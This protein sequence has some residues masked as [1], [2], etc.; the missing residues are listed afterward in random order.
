[1]SFN[2]VDLVKDQIGGSLMGQMG[3]MLGDESSLAA[4]AVDNAVPAL[5]EGLR[6][7]TS[8]SQG[9]DALF[10]AVQ[11]QDDGLLDNLG[12]MLGGGQGTQLIENGTSMLG[13][14][15]G[16]GGLGSLGGVLSAVSG[17]S[18][19]GSGS[20]LGMLAP[21]V[22]GVLKRKVMGNGLNAG[23]LASMLMGQK[24]NISRSMPVGLT[25]QLS[26]TGFLGSISG[27]LGG[28]GGAATGAVAGAGA[29]A[30]GAAAAA[31]GSVGD[32]A[33]GAMGAVG[34]AAGGVR[35]A[36]GNAVSG[37]TG[38]VGDVAGGARDA[39]GGVAGSVTDAAG[40]AVSGV[41]D[42]AGNLAS[43][44]RDAVGGVA[45]SVGDAAG[46]VRDAAGNAV[47]GVTD[48]AGNVAG[49]ARDAVGSVA[50][51]VGDAAG[52]VR[53][54]AGNAV[55]GM[56]DAAGNV[57]DGARDAVGDAAGG[58]R[59]A[60]GNAVGGVTDA[61]GNVVDGARDAVGSVA[62]S[63]G[64]AAG[65]VRDAAGNAV[66]GASGAVGDAASSTANAAA[67]T[68][69]DAQSSGGGW[70]KKLIPLVGLLLLGW[71]G[72]KFFGG[73]AEET[74]TDAA[75][76]TETAATAVAGDIDVGAVGGEVTGFFDSA[77]E[78]FSGI[79]DEASATSS[80]GKLEELSGSL[81]GL[82][83]KFSQIPE[84]ARGPVSDIVNTG[85]ENLTPII[86][87]VQGI[88]GVGGV[89]G[90]V[91]EPMLEMLKGMG[92]Q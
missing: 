69:R 13:S 49:G 92:G 38:A 53:D 47:S 25:D 91:V 66:S 31:A 5:L 48:A 56:T 60:A 37:V 27:G 20:L 70:L 32:V 3:S 83:D 4:G 84:A 58:V 12:G 23:G 8:N 50:G 34:D 2:I 72:L 36:A 86:E 80:I 62:G 22:V 75:S 55:G 79:T 11:D 26:S 14:L 87:K 68:A 40:N 10:Q 54:A 7:S 89:I 9:A 41:S 29:A 46:G 82:N 88:P 67:D 77:T 1:M 51:S 35:D 57:V 28:I 33:G 42:A 76:N 61:A 65:G 39:V 6:N 71:L 17:L 43:G 45:G 19:G 64:D 90:P 59:D 16:S 78:T 21:I 15:F 85:M 24:D 63:V 30:A 18:K 44:A 81:G 73:D 52:G 74:L